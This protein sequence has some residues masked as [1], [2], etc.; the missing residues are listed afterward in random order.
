MTRLNFKVE[1]NQSHWFETIAAFNC[2]P[3]A[4]AYAKACAET[5]TRFQYRV[6]K[7]SLQL[8]AYNMEPAK[9]VHL[10]W[11]GCRGWAKVRA[12]L[13]G[14]LGDAV[15]LY[16]NFAD[17]TTEPGK[18]KKALAG[19]GFELKEQ[20]PNVHQDYCFVLYGVNA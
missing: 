12:I 9:R 14:V 2:E 15:P 13:R 11:S 18:L 19:A 8:E 1:C 10:N 16:G 20:L 7:G 6:K 4:K 5:N 3:A 17:L